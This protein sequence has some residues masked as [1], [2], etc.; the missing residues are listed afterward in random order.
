MDV[1]G[2]HRDDIVAAFD[3]GAKARD[4]VGIRVLGEPG[5]AGGDRRVMERDQGR[6]VRRGVELLL[7]PVGAGLAEAA[8]VAADLER[9]EDEDAKRKALDR[10]LDEA[11]DILDLGEDV[12]EGRPAVMIAHQRED[13]EGQPGDRLLVALVGLG[14]VAVIGDVAGDQQQVR[15][16]LQLAPAPTACESSRNRLNSSGLIGSKPR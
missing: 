13:R 11:A 6:A 15:A 16:R 1:A 7:Q 12:E 3:E 2:D 10:I 14:V 8:A 9:V 4:P 5:D